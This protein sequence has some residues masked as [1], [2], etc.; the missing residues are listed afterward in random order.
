MVVTAFKKT[1]ASGMGPQM[2]KIKV[3]VRVRPL[4]AHEH[5]KDEVVYYPVSDPR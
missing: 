5:S 1:S 3:A 2:S 4:L